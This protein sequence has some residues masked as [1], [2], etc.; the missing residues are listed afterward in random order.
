MFLDKN[1]LLPQLKRQKRVVLELGVGRK[2]G[3]EGAYTIDKLDFPEVDF[4]ADLEDGLSFLDDNSIDEIYSFHFL[5]HVNNLPFLM[6]EIYRVL[7]K[8]GKNIGTVPHFANPYFYSDYTHKNYFGL[9][10]FNYFSKQKYF[11]REVP[12]FYNNTNF[13]VNNVTLE[14]ISPFTLRNYFKKALGIFFNASMYLQEFHEENLCYI[15]P[16][17]QIR[18]ELEKE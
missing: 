8:G 3:I 15:F 6:Q 16:P 4:V 12:D 14:F 2:R 10:S 5:E 13:K 18:F 9:Y 1:N 7:K 11:R 17:Y